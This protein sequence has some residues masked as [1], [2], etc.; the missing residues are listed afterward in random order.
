MRTRRLFWIVATVTF[1]VS[2]CQ[3]AQTRGQD[4]DS[5]GRLVLPATYKGTIPCAD[6]PGIA[7]TLTL[8]ADSIFV[9]RSAYLDRDGNPR[10]DLGRWSVDS[11]HRLVLRGGTAAPRLFDIV[12]AGTVRQLDTQG[13]P[14]ASTSNYD[15]VRAAQVDPIRDSIRLR[16]LFTYF[17]DSARLVEC[18]TGKS[19]RVAQKVDYLA[20]ERAY[21]AGNKAG[22]PALVTLEGHLAMEPRLEG[23]GDEEVIVVDRFDQIQ[24][25]ESCDDGEST[26]SIVG[27]KWT[28]IELNGKPLPE[29]VDPPTM[30]L[31]NDGGRVTGTAG[32]NNVMGTFTMDSGGMHFGR[33]ATTRK[34]CPPAVME[35]EA[36]FLAMLEATTHHRVDGKTLELL[37]TN[38][39][40]AKLSTL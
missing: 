6:C 1:V 5:A 3:R 14:I 13:E 9:L 35:V 39:L 26:G 33:T 25:S 38:G 18:M 30:T 40:L 34:M 24:D 32:C 28:V 37:G 16:G 21:T 20:L 2:G 4:N 12:D 23:N 31:S 10:V 22:R 15:L 27:P 7:T 8:R 19:W 29:G 11:T 36:A 17:A